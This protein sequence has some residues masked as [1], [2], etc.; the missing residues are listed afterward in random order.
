MYYYTKFRETPLL[1]S[2]CCHCRK[3]TFV[4]WSGHIRL[5]SD[6]LLFIIY[7]LLFTANQSLIFYFFQFTL[8]KPKSKNYWIL[9]VKLQVRRRKEI[10]HAEI[11]IDWMKNI[12]FPF[13][14]LFVGLGLLYGCFCL[15][16][17]SF[18]D[19]RLSSYQCI[20]LVVLCWVCCPLAFPQTFRF[21]YFLSVCPIFKKISTWN[22]SQATH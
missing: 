18:C 10:K 22:L 17:L 16:N 4:L 20:F 7:Y 11:E 8:G 13:F 2:R 1:L 3:C 14:F 21:D 12:F 6:L 19:R 15:F 9:G 5:V